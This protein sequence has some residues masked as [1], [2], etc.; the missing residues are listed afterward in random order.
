M[1]EFFSDGAIDLELLRP[2]LCLLAASTGLDGYYPS[3]RGGTY[4]P[5]YEY[6]HVFILYPTGDL[7]STGLIARPGAAWALSIRD[8]VVLW[9]DRINQVYGENTPLQMAVDHLIDRMLSVK[10]GTPAT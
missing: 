3:G 10:F 6:H 5:Y 1:G 4:K 9:L 7:E 8:Q 2:R